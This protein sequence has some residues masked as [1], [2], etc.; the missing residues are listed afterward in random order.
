[1]QPKIVIIAALPREISGLV[2]GWKNDSRPKEKTF[3]YTRGSA[4]VACA[5]M[6][7]QRAVLATRAALKY[8]PVAQ[9]FS[10]GWTGALRLGLQAGAVLQPT[11]VIDA[12]TGEKFACTQ[13]SGTLVTFAQVADAEQKRVLAS[14]YNADCVDME[15]AAVA[16]IAAEM[17]IRFRAIKAVSDALDAELPPL[18]QFTTADGWFRE[19]AFAA[20]IAVRPGLWHAVLRMAANS[21]NAARNL[22]SELR[23]MLLAYEAEMKQ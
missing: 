22:C 2:R 1:M 3:L 6:G 7:A 10:V 8:G 13:G 19:S 9:I 4:V 11:S 23:S 12:A 5:G 18:A 20:H 14:K 17:G 16:R 15:A 21:A